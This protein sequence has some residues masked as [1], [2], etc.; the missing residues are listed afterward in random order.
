MLDWFRKLVTRAVQVPVDESAPVTPDGAVAALQKMNSDAQIDDVWLGLD[1]NADAV[2]AELEE[3]VDAGSLGPYP[4]YAAVLWL[5]YRDANAG[6]PLDERVRSRHR[7][8]CLWAF[9]FE[10]NHV[11]LGGALGTLDGLDEAEREQFAIE[12]FDELGADSLRR[13]WLLLKVRTDA[14][15]ARV[16]VALE[17]FEHADRPRMA[18]AFRQMRAEDEPVLLKH[19]NLDSNG[20]EMW[21]V[22]LG[23]C[24]TAEALALVESAV[25]HEDEHVAKAARL[26]LAEHSG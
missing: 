18:G 4:M 20:A 12:L 2:R 14:L 10:E 19:A 24:G 25:E 13:Y 8:A 1:E 5:G 6:E 15:L 26:V 21:V 17:G 7:E 3:L 11:L 9:G 16:A 23:A 22:A